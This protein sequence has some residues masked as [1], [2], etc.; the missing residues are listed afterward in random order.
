MLGAGQDD[1]VAPRHQASQLNRAAHPQQT[2]PRDVF[3]RLEFIQ[4][5]DARIGDNGNGLQN[6]AR[7][8]KRGGHVHDRRRAAPSRSSPLGGQRSTR[9][10]KRGGDIKN[11]I[12]LGQAVLP[13]HGQRGHRGDA[14]QILQ[15]LRRGRQQTGVAS[16]LVE[17]KAADQRA[18]WFGQ[19]GPGAVQVGKGAA[20]VDVS[21]QQASGF[22]VLR[23]PHVDDV[24]GRQV[25]FGR[26]A[27]ALNHHHVVVGHQRIERFRDVGPDPGAALAPGHGGQRHIDLAQQHHLA[28]GVALGL[29]QQRVHAHIGHRARS[30]RLEVLGAA[31]LATCHHAGVVAHVLRLERRHLQ[32]LAS[33]MPAQ[34]SG[35]PTLASA[36]G[37]AQHHDASGGQ[38]K[39]LIRA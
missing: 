32:A 3:E 38:S 7:S 20:P 14:G 23:H 4:I 25:D 16:E 22:S 12:L 2:H 10:D 15:H 29:E 19:Q 17:H 39:P 31:D 28:V 34:R 37:G 26:R 18:V 1:P 11:T 35:E 24:A 5:A 36:A 8:D 27:C 9:S 30:Q 6:W 21:Y 13:P 33:V